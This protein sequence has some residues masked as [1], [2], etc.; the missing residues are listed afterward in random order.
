MLAVL[1]AHEISCPTPIGLVVHVGHSI[2]RSHWLVCWPALAASVCWGLAPLLELVLAG[3]HI[4][5]GLAGLLVILL[6][7]S[8]L[9]S[10]VSE[11]ATV[12]AFALSL[13]SSTLPGRG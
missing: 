1:C 8:A 11:L 9:P 10:P 3:R 7:G 4:G 2:R 13:A 6:L 5:V 12:V